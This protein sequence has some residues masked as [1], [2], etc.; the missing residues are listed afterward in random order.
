VYVASGPAGLYRS[1]DFAGPSRGSASRQ[2]RQVLLAHERAYVFTA[3][4][5]RVYVASDRGP[6][7]SDDGGNT[8]ISI[9]TDF[10]E[11]A[12]NDSRRRRS[13][14]AVVGAF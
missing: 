8:F 9:A 1:S 13:G 14:Q 12:V 6:Y 7:R 11:L 3:G 10:G 5:T 2:D 4:V